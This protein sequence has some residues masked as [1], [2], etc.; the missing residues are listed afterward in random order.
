MVKQVLNGSSCVLQWSVPAA[1]ALSPLHRSRQAVGTKL[2]HAG[3]GFGGSCFPENVRALTKTAQDQEV[4][5]R[6]LKAIAW[7][8]NTRKWAMARKISTMFAGVLRR[9]GVA[10][11]G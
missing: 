7:V 8:N 3:P 1:L 4:P 2:L 5:L 10:I 11:V 9:K 6:I